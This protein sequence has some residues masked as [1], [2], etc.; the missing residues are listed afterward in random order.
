MPLEPPF[1]VWANDTCIQQVENIVQHEVGSTHSQFVYE[2]VAQQVIYDIPKYGCSNL[3]RWRW[4]IG[5]FDNSRVSSSVRQSVFHVLAGLYQQ[6]YP[7]CKFIG[8]WSDILIWETF[9]YVIRVDYRF[10]IH[11]FTVVGTNCKN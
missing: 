2:F 5:Q 3:T 8:N 10:D 6:R 11:Q 7:P 4:K 9:G 1:P